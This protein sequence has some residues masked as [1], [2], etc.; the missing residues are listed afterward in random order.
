MTQRTR[1]VRNLNALHYP[2]IEKRDRW[3]C[4]SC[5]ALL[6]SFESLAFLGFMAF[7]LA[8]KTDLRFEHLRASNNFPA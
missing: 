6:L 4:K 2:L 7:Y 3:S 5:G 1:F 8:L